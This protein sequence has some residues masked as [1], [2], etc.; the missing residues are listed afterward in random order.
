MVMSPA[1]LVEWK[2]TNAPHVHLV[3]NIIVTV[4]RYEPLASVDGSV[5]YIA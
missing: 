1:A 3:H 2:E 4:A 5:N